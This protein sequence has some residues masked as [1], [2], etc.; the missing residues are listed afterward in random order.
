LITYLLLLCSLL[1]NAFRSRRCLLLEDLALRQQL[2]DLWGGKTPS[3]SG[4][5]SQPSARQTD[6]P[7]CGYA[8][9]SAG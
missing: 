2:A 9:R 4:A 3:V 1:C 5:L 6:A 8:S 7:G